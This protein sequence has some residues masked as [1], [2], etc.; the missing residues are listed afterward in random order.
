MS[1]AKS[2]YEDVMKRSDSGWAKFGGSTQNFA[3]VLQ[4]LLNNQYIP[5]VVSLKRAIRELG[6]KRTDGKSATDDARELR[7]AA[8]AN[9]DAVCAEAQRIPLTP[10]ELQEFGSLS[11]LDLS[12]KYFAEEGDYFR[13]RYDLACRIHGFRPAQRFAS[14]TAEQEDGE[15]LQLT[16]A[17]YHAMPSNLV[18]QRLRTDLK[19]KQAVYTLIAKG[20]I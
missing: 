9:F 8:Q 4:H 17:Q 18:I 2:E 7:A 1:Y 6:I 10:E 5:S 15:T 20:L 3:R 12:R 19:F 11:Q 14:V 16:A 13:I